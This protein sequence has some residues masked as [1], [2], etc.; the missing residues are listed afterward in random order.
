[1]DDFDFLKVLGQGTFGKVILCREK[2]SDKLYAIKIIR[3]EMV[4][5]R[6]EVAHTLTEN[7]VLYACVHPFLTVCL[8]V[9]KILSR[10]T[11]LADVSEN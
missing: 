7:R 2:S 6:S 4:V 5:D 8:L 3:K 9:E 1:M 11:M 10:C